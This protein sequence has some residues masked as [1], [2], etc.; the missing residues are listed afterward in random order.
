MLNAH[1]TRSI[2]ESV[3]KCDRLDA[4]VLGEAVWMA[5]PRLPVYRHLFDRVERKKNKATA[6][7]AMARR[8][9]EDAF[10]LLIR[11]EAFRRGA[12]G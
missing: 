5:V 9:L 8:M 10:A 6:I 12:G 1:K 7:V 2:D 11:N 4:K 3:C